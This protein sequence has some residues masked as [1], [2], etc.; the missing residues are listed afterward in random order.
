MYLDR[1]K[2]IDHVEKLGQRFYE[3][4]ACGLIARTADNQQRR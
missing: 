2:S 3:K 1:Q 4:S